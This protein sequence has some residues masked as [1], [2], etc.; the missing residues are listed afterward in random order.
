MPAGGV[1]RGEGNYC[2][3]VA[4]R[5]SLQVLFR[6]LTIAG[7]HYSPH[8]RKLALNPSPKSGH[9]DMFVMN[10]VSSVHM[11]NRLIHL[12][13]SRWWRLALLTTGSSFPRIGEAVNAPRPTDPAGAACHVLQLHRAKRTAH[14]MRFRRLQALR[15]KCLDMAGATP[16]RHRVPGRRAGN[17]GLIRRLLRRVCDSRRRPARTTCGSR[18]AQVF[19][20]HGD[21]RRPRHRSPLRPGDVV[22]W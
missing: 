18:S 5:P 3:D 6:Q 16:S 4:A 22:V 8:T 17:Q 15:A 11:T 14:S 21:L 12:T 7:S 10:F 19:K 2:F 20:W 1:V 13:R 9:V